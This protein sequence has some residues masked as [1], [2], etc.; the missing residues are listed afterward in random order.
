MNYK[1]HLVSTGEIV[2]SEHPNEV[3]ARPP[4]AFAVWAPRHVGVAQALTLSAEAGERYATPQGTP[5][6]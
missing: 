5:Y 2:G 3:P 1:A 6:N 4:G